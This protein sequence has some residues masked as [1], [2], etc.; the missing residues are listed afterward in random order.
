MERVFDGMEQENSKHKEETDRLGKFKRT[1]SKEWSKEKEEVFNSSQPMW[2]FPYERVLHSW[3]HPRATA[4]IQPSLRRTHSYG[5]LAYN[6]IS[7]S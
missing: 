6:I 1:R 2:R 3:E 4:L 5:N 7:L